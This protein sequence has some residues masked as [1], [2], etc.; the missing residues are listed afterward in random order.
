MIASINLLVLVCAFNNYCLYL[1]PKWGWCYHLCLDNYKLV[2]YTSFY[3]SW[4]I[5]MAQFLLSSILAINRYT[6]LF[7]KEIHLTVS[8]LLFTTIYYNS[9]IC[10]CFL[11]L[12]PLWY[13]QS[14]N[15]LPY[16]LLFQWIGSVIFTGRLLFQSKWRSKPKACRVSIYSILYYF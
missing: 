6:A 9:E 11:D 16:H 4:G 1:F 12:V 15:N 2:I 3:I 14:H 8:N 7:K 10:F 5:G 13:L